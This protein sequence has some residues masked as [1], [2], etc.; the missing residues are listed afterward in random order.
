MEINLQPEAELR[1][2]NG[3]HIM[4]SSP[5]P[6]LSQ[7]TYPCHWLG[8]Q[9]DKVPLKSPENLGVRQGKAFA[10]ILAVELGDGFGVLAG[11]VLAVGSEH[12]SGLGFNISE[13]IGGEVL[14]HALNGLLGDWNFF[15]ASNELFLRHLFSEREGVGPEVGDR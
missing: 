14:A 2:E 11:D 13:A 1:R 12:D 10:V 6:S 7:V 5:L 4:I 9:W 15:G 8:N 3:S